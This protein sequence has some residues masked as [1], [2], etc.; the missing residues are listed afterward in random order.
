[1]LL[2][3]DANIFIDLE[4]AGLTSELFRLPHDIV[5]P[6]ILYEEELASRH[7]DLLKLGLKTRSLTGPQVDEAYRL[8]SSYR[9]P[10]VNDLFALTLAKGLG[11]PLVTGDRRLRAAAKAEGLR[12]LGTLTLMEHIF[13]HSIACLDDIRSAY[14]RMRVGGRRPPWDEVEAQLARLARG[15]RLPA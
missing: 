4:V 5:V 15:L 6:D 7:A 3:S 8:Q 14:Q 10:S 9:E 11:C 1:M 2:V 13:V 12:L